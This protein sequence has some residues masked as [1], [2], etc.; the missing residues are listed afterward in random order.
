[1]SETLEA[2]HQTSAELSPAL[3]LVLSQERLTKIFVVD[4]YPGLAEAAQRVLEANGYEVAAF[5][6]RAAALKAFIYSN[7]RPDLLITDYMGGSMTGF[8]LITICK[9]LHPGMKALLVS[10]IDVRDLSAE[11]FGLIDGALGKPYSAAD[12][13]EEVSRLERARLENL[14]VA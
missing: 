4:D 8:R 3:R 1:M 7:P 6:N 2:R 5:E 13:L 11:E 14:A 10:G 12:L 9:A